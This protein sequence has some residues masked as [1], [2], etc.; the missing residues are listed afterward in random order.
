[1]SE[2]RLRYNQELFQKQSKCLFIANFLF[3][4]L[5]MG[6]IV[7]GYV[8]LNKQHKKGMT[9]HFLCINGSE[10]VYQSLMGNIFG[11]MLQLLILM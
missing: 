9:Q 3:G 5:S 1:M 6:T 2:N 4:V 7:T 8:I 10:W 11:T